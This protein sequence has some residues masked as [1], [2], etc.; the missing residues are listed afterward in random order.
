MFRHPPFEYISHILRNPNHNHKT[1]LTIQECR[2]LTELKQEVSR[3]VLTAD[4]GVA[5][6]I[7]DKEDCT[8]K[9]QALLQDTNTYKVLNKDPTTILKN[10]LKQTLKDIKQSGG[11]S[12]SE[13][14]ETVSHKCC[15][16]SFMASP[17][18]TKLAP[19]SGP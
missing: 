4:K 2:A 12:D 11:I 5:M 14:Q 9:A 13:V 7:M 1:N 6:V 19:S 15:P 3:V 10:K 17:K 16:P 18:Y 8:N